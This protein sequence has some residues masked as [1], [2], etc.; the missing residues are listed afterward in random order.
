MSADRLL[1][2][3]EGVKPNGPGRWL[4]KCPAHPDNSPSLS[5]RDADDRLLVHCFAGCEAHDIVAAVGLTLGDL[6]AKPLEHSAPLRDRRHQHAACEALKVLSHES[7]V[8]LIAAENIARG[9]PLSD[10][11]RDR[12]TV[13]AVRIRNVREAAA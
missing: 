1:D 2:R 13:A 9:R 8:A 7:L 11:D 12:L 6:F 10:E 4:A 5:I 3:L